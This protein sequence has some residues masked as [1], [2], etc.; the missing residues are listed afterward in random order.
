[1][2][3]IELANGSHLNAAHVTEVREAYGDVVVY[4]G[5]EMFSVFSGD[6]DAE[7]KEAKARLL[8]LLKCDISF[9]QEYLALD[10]EE[11]E[12]TFYELYDLRA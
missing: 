1:M 11:F 5:D 4:I 8:R 12:R 2:V 6:M 10:S 9:R 7:I 3:F